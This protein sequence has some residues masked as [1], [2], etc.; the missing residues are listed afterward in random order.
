MCCWNHEISENVCK[1]YSEKDT[2]VREANEKRSKQQ[3]LEPKY[4]KRPQRQECESSATKTVQNESNIM[5]T[6]PSL[7]PFRRMS[8]T[9]QNLRNTILVFWIC[10][11][12]CH[13]VHR[14]NSNSGLLRSW[15]K[16]WLSQLNGVVCLVAWL[17]KA[18][19]ACFW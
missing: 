8:P 11:F 14:M 15:C 9:P 3:K 13:H 10:V 12:R 17:V 16:C 6:R 4:K 2:L 1:T 7:P 18:E 19:L 5:R